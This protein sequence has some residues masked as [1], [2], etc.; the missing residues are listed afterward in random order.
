MAQLITRTFRTASTDALLV[1]SGLTPIDYR[2][3][4]IAA[5]RA[6]EYAEHSFCP[7][8]RAFASC[9]LKALPAPGGIDRPFSHHS[10]SLPPWLS[11]R[12]PE[13]I[14]VPKTPILPLSPALPGIIRAY[15]NGS[16]FGSAQVGFA[17]VFA[18]H[19]GPVATIQMTLTPGSTIFQAE[20]LAFFEALRWLDQHG[21]SYRAGEI[22]SDSLSVLTS[23]LQAPKTT[24]TLQEC[25]DTLHKLALPTALF[26]IPSCGVL[27]Y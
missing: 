8:S 16:V 5:L 9:H 18:D 22:Y 7:S 4:E 3:Q 10:S 20:S 17:V 19:T 15:T 26:W 14:K 2:I 25:R 1:L 24:L 6:I 13:I 23:T 12:L 21:Q 11:S 27:W